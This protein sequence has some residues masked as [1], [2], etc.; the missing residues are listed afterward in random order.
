MKR[1][2]VVGK[3][4]EKKVEDKR[5][6]KRRSAEEQEVSAG[7]AKQRLIRSEEP[8]LSPTLRTCSQG[9]SSTLFKIHES[10]QP[11]EKKRQPP[12]IILLK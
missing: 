10:R 6:M 4:G 1:T 9:S 7:G 2:G 5:K 8:R 12:S 3:G 11:P